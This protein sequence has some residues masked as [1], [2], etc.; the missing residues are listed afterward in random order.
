MI[1]T[2][3]QTKGEKQKGNPKKNKINEG[4]RKI[5]KWGINIFKTLLVTPNR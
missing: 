4:L 3:S 5:N 1:N 2:K